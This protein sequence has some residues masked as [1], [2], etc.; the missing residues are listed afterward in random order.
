MHQP[1]DNFSF[2][3]Q[4]AVEK[5]YQPFFETMRRHPEFKFAVHC[6]GWLLEQIENNHP[7][8]FT[9]MGELSQKGSIEWFTAGYYEPVLSSIPSCDRRA[10]IQKLNSFLQSRFGV[11]AQG[12]WLTERVW[13]S[14]LVPDLAACGVKYSVVDDYHFVSSTFSQDELDGYY[15]TEEGGD[16][17]ALF[18]ISKKLRYVLPFS[19]VDKAIETI[20]SYANKPNSCAIFFDDAEK[21][22]LWPNTH[23]WVYNQGWL[24]SFATQVVENKHIISTHY[25]DFIQQ[26]RS[27]GIVYLNNTS[28]FEMGEW[29]LSDKNAQRLRELKEKVGEEYFENIGISFIK[30]GIWKNFFVKYSESN[31]IHKRMLYLSAQQKSFTQKQQESLYKLQ[32]N[33][34]FWHGVFG[35]IY[36]P[37]LRDNAYRYLLEI[38][39]QLDD[40]HL[41][42]LDINK[43]GFEELKVKTS[44]LSLVFSSRHSASL[45][46]FGSFETLFNWQN[47]MTRY[48]E[49]YHMQDEEEHD[50][51][52]IDSIH[53]GAKMDDM[54]RSELHFDKSPRY[55][56]MDHFSLQKPTLEDFKKLDFEDASD[57]TDGPFMLHE[58]TQS[59]SKK[60]L[61]YGQEVSLSKT[62]ICHDNI[63]TLD[64]ALQ[65]TCDTEL[66]YSSE[67]NF[68]FAHIF[69]VLING[70]KVGDGLSLRNTKEIKIFDDFTNKVLLITMPQMCDIQAC[71]IST[72][73]KSEKGFDRTPQQISLIATMPLQ[74]Q[75]FSIS[76]GLQNV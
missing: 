68:H 37:N 22:G 15:V 73:S 24:D 52:Q 51:E 64:V 63:I 36:L 65:G 45:M 21:F 17:N 1:V 20:L 13:E 58:N 7:E 71:I 48:S 10:Q 23:D 38:E 32:T 6:S 41:Q 3:I 16:E 56:F 43:D 33:D 49:I 18:P 47:T 30:G 74:S 55:S 27:K 35:G 19:T 40:A 42:V 66:Y 9:L 76:L 39:K 69:E 53:D 2:C 57:F 31:Y 26:N 12:L 8:L 28:Y 67:F 25:K 50:K 75:S 29:S 14:S 62:Y 34:V 4:E 46:E 44:A 11:E 72:I 60:G 59:F 54:M 5:S 61:L 70:N